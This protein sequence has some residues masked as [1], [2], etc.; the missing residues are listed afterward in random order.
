M[1]EKAAMNTDAG[2]YVF[3]VAGGTNKIDVRRAVEA[4]YS[5][6]VQGVNMLNTHGKE[7]HRGKQIGWKP[8]FRKAI[9]TLRK[10]ETIDIQ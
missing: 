1:T 10:G 7:L 8:G 5:V 9:V 2:K 4:R 3:R 6:H